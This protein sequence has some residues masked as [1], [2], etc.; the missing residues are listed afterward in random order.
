MDTENTPTEELI[1]PEVETQSE[2][3][4]EAEISSEVTPEIA[5][6]TTNWEKRYKDA[7]SQMTK[8]AQENARLRESLENQPKV[9]DYPELDP[10][11]AQAVLRIVQEEQRKAREKAEIEKAKQFA[12]KH[13]DKLA[14]PVLSGTV[15][16]LI[17]EAKASGSYLDQ[18]EA[19]RQ[20]EQL[21]DAR[22]K[23]QASKAKQQ[24]VSEGADLAQ[25]RAELGKVGETPTSQKLDPKELSA[26]EYAK[27]FNLPRAKS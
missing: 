8:V 1:T 19:L 21:L 27:Y 22:I 7:Q 20:A 17:G 6:D 3:V 2:Q 26:D 9:E 12:E 24:G 5:E 15:M 10:Q 14:D 4:D 25:K 11:S 18:E 23:T 16:R 13:A